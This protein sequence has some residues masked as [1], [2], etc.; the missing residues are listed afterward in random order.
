[1]KL[2]ELTQGKI[3]LVDD[4]DFEMLSQFKWCAA[5]FGRVTKIFYAWTSKPRSFMHHMILGLPTCGL[6]TDHLN[7]NG[8]DNRRLNIRHVTNREN[9]INKHH[10]NKTSKYPGVTI[11]KRYNKWSSRIK[12]NGKDKSLGYFID[13]ESAF[14]AYKIAFKELT[15]NE[16]Y[17]NHLSQIRD[18]DLQQ[19]DERR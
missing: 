4:E 18:D 6:V 16:I 13:E 2:I 1:M 9:S 14:F 15:G 19:H 3:A 17:L 8:L 7:G 10:K 5:K 11:D 12:I